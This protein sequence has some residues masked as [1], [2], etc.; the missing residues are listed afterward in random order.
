MNRGRPP[1]PDILTPRQLEV[2]GFLR[3]GLTNDQ[4]AQRLG[5]TE[6]GARY[7]VSEILSKLGVGSREEAAAWRGERL[8]ALLSVPSS[9]ARPGVYFA[10]SVGTVVFGFGALVLLAL[11]LGIVAMSSRSG[12]EAPEQDDSEPVQE[13]AASSV[14]FSELVQEAQA[15]AHSVMPDA[16]L[17]HV[18]YRPAPGANNGG[19]P[20]VF[21]FSEPTPMQELQVLGPYAEPDRP[22][23][24]VRVLDGAPNIQRGIQVPLDLTGLQ[25]GPADVG[26]VVAR[27]S[28]IPA[29]AVS[30]VLSSFESGR[31]GWGVA[32]G[33]AGV[34]CDLPDG[35]DVFQ[36]S[37]PTPPG[38]IGGPPGVA[39][40]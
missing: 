19:G 21:H 23:W 33:F 11:A 1:H 9:L 25:W 7:H 2:L 32:R 12:G 5:I 37:C 8:P 4:I 17:Y 30:V 38:N 16:V 22:R 31:P 27:Q 34:V 18:W 24:E 28:G 29:A 35:A 26:E 15:E 3:M 10:R 40:P 39:S 14:R 36:I 13:V 20:Y 6:R